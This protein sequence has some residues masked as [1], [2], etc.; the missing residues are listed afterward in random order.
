MFHHRNEKCKIYFLQNGFNPIWET[1]SEFR[2]VYPELTFIEFQVRTLKED[3]VSSKCS[4]DPVIGS[5]IVP[6]IL[7]QQGYRHVYLEDESGH[8]LT[9][10][11]LFIHVAVI[12]L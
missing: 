1:S 3:E 2:L 7:L 10:A 8:R 6:Y 11:C 12:E 9:P 4:D 5:C